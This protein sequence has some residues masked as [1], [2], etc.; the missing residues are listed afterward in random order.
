[1]TI[2]EIAK[3]IS[4]REDEQLAKAFTMVIGSLLQSKGIQPI[5][6]KSIEEWNE[7]DDLNKYIIRKEYNATFDIDTTEHD[8]QVREDAFKEVERAMYHQCFEV[9]NDE[10][11]QKWDSGNWFRYK[12]FE[13][14]MD[15]LKGGAEN[16]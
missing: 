9:N 4:K 12:L 8:K 3:D 2:E 14:V 15:K 7:N 10:E 5:I 6:N 11:M 16:E 13:N 1:M